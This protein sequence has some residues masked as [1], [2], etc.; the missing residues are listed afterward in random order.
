MKISECRKA[1]EELSGKAGEITRQS[2]YAGIATIWAVKPANGLPADLALSGLL[3]IL[4]LSADFLT[5]V[6][7]SYIWAIFI[8]RK[9]VQLRRKNAQE[10]FTL[11]YTINWPYNLFAF[12]RYGLLIVSYIY[13]LN[14]LFQVYRPM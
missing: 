9:E 14:Y 5:Y 1:Y 11:H 6:I 2:A 8:R 12:L 7:P 10:D 13:L 3:L 4:T